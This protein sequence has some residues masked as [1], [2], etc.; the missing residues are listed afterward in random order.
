MEAIA[1][2]PNRCET[3][4]PTRSGEI[5]WEYLNPQRKPDADTPA[6]ARRRAAIYRA[7]R[8]AA[9]ELPWLSSEG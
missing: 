2:T 7:H 4:R 3:P 1:E 6:A 5:V 8:Y 9:D